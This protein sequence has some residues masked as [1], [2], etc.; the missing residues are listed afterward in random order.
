MI[1]A[2]CPTYDGNR[3]NA[4][5]L[6]ELHSVG[7][8]VLEIQLSLLTRAFN[9]LLAEALNR[10]AD[11]FLMLHAD[12]VPTTKEWPLILQR[13]AAAHTADLL[14]V[15]LPIKTGSGA[16]STAVETG[17]PW[18]PHRLDLE[19]VAKRPV[20][21]TEPGLLV[22]TGLMLVNLK[23]PWARDLC[24]TFHNRILRDGWKYVA[25]SIPE[26]WDFS[27]Q[28]HSAGGTVYA[29]RVI[30]AY[31]YGLAPWPNTLRES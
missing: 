12:V 21:W 7:I 9:E 15:V 8:K 26:D 28:V 2:G 14:S 18:H 10:G 19:D 16:T 4:K 13:E 27:R 1:I 25:E 20:T 5:A 6:I 23:R 22:N 31:H 24:F 11:S 30:E 29:T 17:D 3:L